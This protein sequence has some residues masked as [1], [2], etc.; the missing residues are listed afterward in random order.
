MTATID[1]M[2][3]ELAKFKVENTDADLVIQPDVKRI[4]LLAFHE[5]IKS[6]K[7]GIEAAESAV[8]N[9]KL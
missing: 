2:R 3:L 8:N 6:Y 4:G 5:G 1:I 9:L 7:K